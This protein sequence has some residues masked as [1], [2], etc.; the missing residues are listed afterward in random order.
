[1]S[2]QPINIAQPRLNLLQRSEG[3]LHSPLLD[4][5]GLGGGSMIALLVIALVFDP[6]AAYPAFTAAGLALTLIINHPHFAHSYQ[7]FYANF[8]DKLSGRG[9]ASGL[10]A[11]YWFAGVIAPTL[12]VLGVLGSFATKNAAVMGALINLM[13]FMVGW[14]YVKQGYGM[15]ML[16]AAIKRRFFSNLEKRILLINA[17]ATWAF[18]WCYIGRVL[19]ER[20]YYGFEAPLITAP[21]VIF[22]TSAV[23]AIGTFLALTAS[24]V[25]RLAVQRKT[26]PWNGLFAYGISLYPWLLF[27]EVNPLFFILVPAFHSLQYMTVVWRYKLN[28]LE[29]KRPETEKKSRFGF[30]RFYGVAVL[31]GFFG[32]YGAPII[33]TTTFNTEQS[34]FGA[35]IYFLMF[36][37]FINVHHYLLD[38]VMW[39]KGNP[40]V[41]ERLFSAPHTNHQ[42]A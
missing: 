10:R 3:W 7:I 21:E 24:L 30:L 6:D 33:L 25:Y 31:L 11:R 22:F 27:R 13:F 16:D 40:D 34:F 32:F 23:I 29:T 8:S 15:A 38:N 19:E 12:L 1:M 35:G 37:L 42:S 9:Y 26:L 39:R 2:V 20:K 36:S 28:E 17:Y 4:F 41:A 14:H 5:L 18:S